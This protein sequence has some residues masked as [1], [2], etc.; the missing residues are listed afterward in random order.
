[1]E[2][3][4]TEFG[5]EGSF[6][7]A[8]FAGG[9]FWCMESDFE[10]VPGVKD[11]LSGYIGGISDNP[12]YEDYH[13]RGFTEAVE[14]TYDPVQVT[15][16]QLLNYFWRH[17]DPEDAGGQFCDRGTAY[18]SAI[19]YISDK[20][21][22]SADESKVQLEKSGKLKK[23]IATKI[24]EAGKFYPA[25]DYHQEYY[26]KN[27]VRYKFYRFNCGRDRRVKEIWGDSNSKKM[28]KEELKMKLTPIQYKVTQENGTEPAFQ[29]DY[30]NNHK[31]GIYVDIVSGEPL[32]SSQDKYES[33]TGW[34][35][36]TKPLE[37][38]N[39]V[40]KVD[41]SLFSVRT[42]IR[43]KGADSHLGHVFNDGPA[44]TG[45][46]YCMNSVALR[47]VPKEDLEKEG[48]G[49]YLNLFKK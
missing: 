37:P 48:Y 35:S 47:F 32:F 17:I 10:K 22:K 33:G 39:I 36:F 30:W 4:K 18:L 2:N 24:L 31:D 34:P 40:E 26:K 28:K 7:K 46:R 41:R 21:K 11:A 44:P 42:E 27:P 9:C 16:E 13:E 19:Y 12:T 25:E 38:S 23:P 20:Q 14:V 15:Y 6:E 5:K 45:L 43:S 49:K 8:I 29:N 1:M 3:I